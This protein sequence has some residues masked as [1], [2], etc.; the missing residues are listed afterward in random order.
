MRYFLAWLLLHPLFQTI[1]EV[2]NWQFGER[3]EFSST[4]EGVAAFIS[5]CFY[6][7]IANLLWENRE[8]K[9]DG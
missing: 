5:I 7:F 4:T 6:F 2:L 9:S 3:R 8:G 1:C